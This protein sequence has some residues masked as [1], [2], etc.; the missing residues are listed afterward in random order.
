MQRAITIALEYGKRLNDLSNSLADYDSLRSLVADYP[1]HSF[2]ID[3]KEAGQLF[4]KVG[5]P[6]EGEIIFYERFWN[7]LQDESNFGPYVLS[8]ESAQEKY[9][10]END[11]PE[12]SDVTNKSELDSSDAPGSHSPANRASCNSRKNNERSASHSDTNAQKKMT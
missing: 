12:A 8:S 2:V 11:K 10:N 7:K 6:T 4:A 5:H 9:D 3:R 1:S